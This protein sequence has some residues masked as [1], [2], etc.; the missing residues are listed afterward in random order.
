MMTAGS[1]ILVT[2]AVLTFRRPDDLAAVLPLLVEQAVEAEGDGRRV[3]VLVVD[4]D[5]AGSA[6][7]VVERLAFDQVRYV[8]EETP[9]ISAAR[10]RALAEAGGAFLVFIDDDERPHPG[11]LTQLL[12]TQ[13]RTCAAA[14]VGP[15]V[16]DFDGEL[17][18]W[19]RAGGF[20]ERRRLATGT[21]ITVAA[22]NNLLLDLSVIRSTGVRFDGQFG[23]T[24]GSDTL[25]TR[26]LTG[27]GHLMVWCDEAVVT[28][29]VPGPR[30]SR[31][32]VVR[33]S[34]RYGNGASRVDLVLARSASGRGL[35]RL[36]AAARGLPRLTVGLSRWLL[37]RLV[38]SVTHEARGLR[39]AARGAGMMAGAF[40]VVYAE[41]RR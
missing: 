10:N 6:R 8:V 39:T 11:W 5:A 7:P 37:G 32:W 24:G 21:P 34:F 1:D 18:P 13:A 35:A 16:S 30:M 27:A 40:G 9:G 17:D 36:R 31:D 3:E 12:D 26:Q 22:T 14:V 33:R 23:L 41:Y 25:F 28:D 38:R 15:V 2:V 19:V 20:F 29:H 4:N